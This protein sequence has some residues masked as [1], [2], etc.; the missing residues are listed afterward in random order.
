M[1][2]L[3]VK[4]S[5]WGKIYHYASMRYVGHST[6]RV[7]TGKDRW[8]GTE[9]KEA[10]VVG[11]SEGLSERA[12]KWRTGSPVTEEQRRQ[13]P[14][15][16]KLEVDTMTNQVTMREIQEACKTFDKLR[17]SSKLLSIGYSSNGCIYYQVQGQA[18]TISVDSSVYQITNLLEKIKEDPLKAKLQKSLDQLLEKA[19]EIKNQIKGM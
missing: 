9:Y 16:N 4:F 1:Y 19:E 3:K 8:G 7:A 12:T 5:S 14:H 18:N 15:I 11:H 10:I 6:C 17:E 13:Y 2:T